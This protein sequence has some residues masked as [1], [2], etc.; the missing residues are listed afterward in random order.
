M[1]KVQYSGKCNRLIQQDFTD[2]LDDHELLNLPSVLNTETVRS[3]VGSVNVYHC[4]RPG[5]VVHISD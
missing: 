3:S 1:V 4:N 5:S 2:D